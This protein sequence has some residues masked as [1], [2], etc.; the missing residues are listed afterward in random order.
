MDA[1]LDTLF[2]ELYQV[3]ICVGLIARRQVTM[4]SFA[5]EASPPPLPVASDSVSKDKD[6]DDGDDDDAS[7]DVDRD[8]SSTDEMFT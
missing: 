5:P 1:R 8:A 4:G 6:D 2:T 7:T 3:N